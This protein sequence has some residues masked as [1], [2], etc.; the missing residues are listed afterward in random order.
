MIGIDQSAGRILD[1]AKVIVKMAS[2]TTQVDGLAVHFDLVL[3]PEKA[4][5]SRD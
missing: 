4:G 5:I 1:D 2:K 3:A